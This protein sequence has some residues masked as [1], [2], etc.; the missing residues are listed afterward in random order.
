MLQ[1]KRAHW[2]KLD[3]AGTLFSAASSAKDTRVFRFYCVLQEEIKEKELTEALNR[4]LDKYPVFLS[5]MRKGLFW[6]YLEKSDLWPIVREEYKEPCSSLYVRDKKNLL[7]EVTY[8]KKRINF[9]VFHALTDGTGAT[10]FLK[11]LVKNYLVLAKQEELSDIDLTD[12][13]MTIQDQEKDSF[14]KYYSPDKIKRK[15]KKRKAYQIKKTAKEFSVLRVTEATASVKEVL[16]V[17]REKHVS[18]TVLLSAVLISA[19]HGEMSS[20]QEKKPIVLMIPVNLR[21]FFPS[22]SMLNFFGWIEPGYKFTAGEDSFEQVLAAVN[23]YFKCYLTKEHISGQMNSLIAL[24]QNQILKWAPLEIKNR[25]IWAGSKLAEREVTAVLSNMNAVNMPEKFSP[26]I[27]RFGVYTSTPRSELCVCSFEDVLSFGFTS[28]YDSSNIQR[29]FFR[30]LGQMGIKVKMVSAEYP[31]D[32]KPNHEGIKFFQSFSF[33]CIV[34][35]VVGIMLN[36]FIV[37]EVYWSV[38][39]AAGAASM[40]IPLAIGFFKRRNLLKNAMWQQFVVSN[41]CIL[42]D[43]LT[44]W[45]GWSVN[46]VL[47]AV[48]IIIELSMLVISRLQSYTERE[49]M[50]YYVMASGYGVLLPFILLLTGVITFRFLAVLCCGFSFLFL[51]SLIFF[52]GHA[53]KEEMKK[54]FHV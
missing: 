6:H 36:A 52:K 34:A 40:W 12:E 30:I 9:E 23:E 49:Y 33:V 27:E 5:V 13:Y 2:R 28:R 29:N 46:Y 7:F 22:E 51:M 4:T 18:M 1:Q 10:E 41:G 53:F 31:K 11:E 15:K 3:N 17:S 26:Y 24:E 48:C 50:I 37:P 8:Y 35:V 25:F 19:I 21:K 16:A 38:F 47:P 42:W 44:G 14:L 45:R 32:A 39:V 54:K 20:I 43:L